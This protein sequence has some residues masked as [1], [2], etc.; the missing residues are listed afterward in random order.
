VLELVERMLKSSGGRVDVTTPF[1]DATLPGGHRL[2][3]VPEGISRD[4]SAVN[5]PT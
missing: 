2:H 4:S 1:V 3:V 5:A